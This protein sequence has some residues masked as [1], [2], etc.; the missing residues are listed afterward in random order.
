MSMRKRH[1]AAACPV[2]PV[3][4]VTCIMLVLAESSPRP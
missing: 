2:V 3:S 4:S 1:T